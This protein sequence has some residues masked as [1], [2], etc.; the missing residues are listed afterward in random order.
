MATRPAA[1]KDQYGLG[2]VEVYLGR[3]A[4]STRTLA[5][6]AHNEESTI[7]FTRE[8][9]SELMRTLGKLLALDEPA[10]T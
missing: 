1:A 5:H 4:Y 2:F 6:L 8:E 9:A 3:E 10:A 7:T